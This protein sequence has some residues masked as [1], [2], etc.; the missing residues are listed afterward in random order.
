VDEEG[1]ARLVV[2]R[3]SQRD[4]KIRGLDILLDGEYVANIGY[5]A[6]YSGLIRAGEH[7]LSVTNQLYTRRCS[8]TVEPG[9]SV[10]F[11]AGNVAN[12]L[13]A[14]MVGVLGIGPYRCFLERLPPSS[15]E[16]ES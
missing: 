3:D 11:R 2:R 16:S 5:G 7:E 10:S 6:E 4:I 8:F 15:G 13:T 1:S 9:G 12:G 14:I